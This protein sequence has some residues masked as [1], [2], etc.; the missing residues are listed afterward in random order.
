MLESSPNALYSEKTIV[1]HLLNASTSK[2]SVSNICDDTL[3][4]GT[5]RY[6]LRNTDLDGIQQSSNEKLKIHAIKIMNRK[7]DLAIDYT[8][9]SYY[10]EEESYG[11]TIKIKLKQETSRFFTYASIY[12]IVRNKRYTVAVKYIRK[13]EILKDVID[14]LI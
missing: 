4:E 7:I 13:G 1:H 10:G 12:A 6:R 11:D 9:K 14:F 5:I 8:N 3:C 2:T